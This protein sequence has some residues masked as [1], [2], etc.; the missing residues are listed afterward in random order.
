MDRTGKHK[1]AG[2]SRW[3]PITQKHNT[4]VHENHY[5][6]GLDIIKMRDEFYQYQDVVDLL[7]DVQK[8]VDTLQLIY[9][10]DDILK[11]L[12]RIDN[13]KHQ[14]PIEVPDTERETNPQVGLP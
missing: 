9:K 3:H 8:G 13:I 12:M 1:H 10:I 6:G 2:Y 14:E 7:N 5:I 11:L 4:T